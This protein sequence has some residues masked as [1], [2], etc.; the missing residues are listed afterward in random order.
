[1]YFSDEEAANA[2]DPVLNLIE[3]ETRRPTLLAARGTRDGKV[4]CTFDIHLQGPNET[5][6]FDV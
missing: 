3:Q 4:V 6:F 1:M 2:A 5:I